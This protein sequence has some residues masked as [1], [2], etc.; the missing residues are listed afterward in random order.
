MSLLQPCRQGSPEKSL[1]NRSPASTPASATSSM[2]P[3]SATTGAVQGTPALPPLRAS[4][5][6]KSSSADSKGTKHQRDFA[7]MYTSKIAEY[8]GVCDHV[9]A[10]AP[11]QYRYNVDSDHLYHLIF[12]DVFHNKKQRKGVKQSQKS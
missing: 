1:T 12:I 7:T 2:T 5:L 4:I 3:S 9:Y 8:Y 6:G 11:Q 10:D